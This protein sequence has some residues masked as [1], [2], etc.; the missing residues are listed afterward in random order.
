MKSFNNDYLRT[1]D[2]LK[3][4]IFH[5][6]KEQIKT[7]LR[8]KQKKI[9]PPAIKKIFPWGPLLKLSSLAAIS[10]LLYNY[11]ESAIDSAIR[12]NYITIVDLI[13]LRVLKADASIKI[14]AL[15]NFPS[16][17]DKV[18]HFSN[19]KFQSD[20]EKDL[21]YLK[22][23]YPSHTLKTSIESSFKIWIFQF[24]NF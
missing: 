15:W 1:Y 10:Y 3:D 20:L 16:E 13:S 19:F 4:D 23:T 21:T 22:K 7:D 11:T 6:K 14:R 2:K 17:I 9:Q 12:R 5:S 8:N 24:K 18:A